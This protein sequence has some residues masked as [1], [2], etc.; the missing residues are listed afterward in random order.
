MYGNDSGMTDNNNFNNDLTQSGTYNT[1]TN[2]ETTTTT[3]TTQTTTYGQNNTGNSISYSTASPGFET[4][5]NNTTTTTTT[6]TDYNNYETNSFSGF[7]DQRTGSNKKINKW[8]III[9]VVIFLLLI[10]ILI[11][12]LS[13]QN[14]YTVKTKKIDIKIDEEQAIE[15]S[16]K[17]DVKKKITCKSKDEKIAK[18]DDCKVKGVA[19]GNTEVYVGLNGKKTYTIKVK[20]ATNK[21]EL[22]FKE[23]SYTVA[24]DANVQIELAK[25]L[26]DDE[27]TWKSQ[28]ELVAT[29]DEN[30]LVTGIHGG[31]TAI[32]VTESDGRSAKVN[33]NV[34]SDEVLITSMSIPNQTIGIGG[35]FKINPVIT[36]ANGL[37]IL[38]YSSS[39]EAVAIVDQNGNV[40]GVSEGTA[41]ITVT[42]HNGIEAKATIT[43]DA[44]VPASVAITGCQK[45]IKIGDSMKLDATV[46]PTSAKKTI[47]WTSSNSNVATVSGGNVKGVKK[48]TA[49]ITA[50][51]VNGLTSTCKVSVGNMT[52]TKLTLSTTQ[53]NMKVGST[54]MI[55]ARFTPSS[56]QDYYTVKWR[57]QYPN[58]V[59]VDSNGLLVAKAAGTSYVYATAGGKKAKARVTVTGSSSSSSGGSSSSSTTT[60]GSSGST[61]STSTT[62]GGSTSGGST[63]TNLKAISDFTLTPP[64]FSVKKNSYKDVTITPKG[65]TQAQYKSTYNV[66]DI[67]YTTC[68]FI[69]VTVRNVN[70]IRI[71]GK[72]VSKVGCT[73]HIQVNKSKPYTYIDRVL[74]VTA[75]T[76]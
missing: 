9:P 7:E 14:K 63:S 8:L 34:T 20:V 24:K 48:G 18:V 3:T 10:L 76:Q 47:T 75:V 2:T 62:S 69:T 44:T 12:I 60:S 27:F 39:R 5:N 33:V 71:T 26:D 53:V 28:N 55:S 64:S 65:L 22:Q 54:K 45:N 42:S 36:P 25:V 29:V 16:A 41:K 68:S 59:S 57:S 52:L 1:N 49:V 72:S 13:N 32:V 61:T 23:E 30:G 51:T 17:S 37:K 58:I 19:V 38:S 67:K 43:V 15:I 66:G 56:A 31:K 35:K 21:E 73:V 74:N 4:N 70:T 50:T 11:L 6:T 40:Q 46:N